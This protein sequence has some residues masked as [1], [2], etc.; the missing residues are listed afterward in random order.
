MK[1]WIVGMRWVKA[2]ARG[3]ALQVVELCKSAS[4][5]ADTASF[6]ILTSKVMLYFFG[7]E[8]AA[9]WSAIGCWSLFAAKHEAA[10]LTSAMILRQTGDIVG[11][12]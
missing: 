5:M 10:R 12:S 9:T 1:C 6:P 8:S 11:P 3:I 4:T 7:F 2:N